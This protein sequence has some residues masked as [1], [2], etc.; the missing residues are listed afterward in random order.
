MIDRE[1]ALKLLLEKFSDSYCYNC[2][3][4]NIDEEEAEKLYNNYGCE[5]CHRKYMGWKIDPVLA[6]AII[7]KIYGE[8]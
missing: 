5:F 1:D 4:N 7:D 3:F 2:A 6:T 8:Q